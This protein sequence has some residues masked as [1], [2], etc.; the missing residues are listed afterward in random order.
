MSKIEEFLEVY[1]LYRS[2]H[3]IFY[4]A[5]IAFGVAFKNKPF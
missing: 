5:K 4:A 1:R 3:S 2:H